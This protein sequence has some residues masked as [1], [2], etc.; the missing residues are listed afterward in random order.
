MYSLELHNGSGTPLDGF[1]LQFNKNTFGLAP[2]TQNIPV[3]SIAPGASARAAVPVTQTPAMLSPGAANAVLQVLS[4][5]HHNPLD[6]HL[7]SPVVSQSPAMRQLVFPLLPT[8]EKTRSCLVCITKCLCK[9]LPGQS[10]L[11]AG[12]W[13]AG[14]GV[15][16]HGL[17]MQVAVRNN[18]QG[19]FYFNDT[20]PLEA[21][22]LEEG[23]LQPSEFI[24]AWRA[25]PDASE[26]V[27]PIQARGGPS[28]ALPSLQAN[29]F[30]LQV[31]EHS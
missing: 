30:V 15:Q 7:L 8:I 14:S 23:S 22:L 26:T 27:Q 20:I 6:Y 18:Q 19:V 4:M 31:S 16:I 21:L 2:A 17:G 29:Y 25:L 24:P 13:V 11:L 10:I 1:M 5:T 9:C 12:V 3:P 28:S